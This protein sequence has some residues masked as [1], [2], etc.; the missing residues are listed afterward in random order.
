VLQSG[1][2]AVCG[3][4]G[5]V[6]GQGRARRGR[7]FARGPSLTSGEAKKLPEGW[8]WGRARQRG[9]ARGL[10]LTSGEAKKLRPKASP[11]GLS[12]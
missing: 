5:V 7:E 6:G 9:C 3:I 2:V 10:D 1:G 4:H 8:T 12:Y 11:L